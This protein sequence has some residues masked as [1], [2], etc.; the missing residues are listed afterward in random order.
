MV[1]TSAGSVLAALLGAG[2]GVDELLNHHG[3]LPVTTGPLAGHSYD[4]DRATG[5]AMPGRPR[6]G[7]GSSRLLLQSMRSPRSIRRWLP[8]RRCSRTVASRCGLF[9]R[10]SRRSPRTATGRRTRRCGSWPWTTT[11]DG[12]W[13][14]VVPAR[15]LQVWPR[16]STRLARSPVVSRGPIGGRRYVDGGTCSPTSVD[17]LAGADVDEVY[18]LAPMI[19]FDY[20]RPSGFGARAE[21]TFRRTM[22][23]RMLGEAAKVRRAGISVTMLGPGRED[24]EAIGRQ[25]DGSEPPRGRTRGLATHQRRGAAAREGRRDQLHLTCRTVRRPTRFGCTSPQ[26]WP[27]LGRCSAQVSLRPAARAPSQQPCAGCCPTRTLRPWSTRRC[28]TRPSCPST[29]WF[30]KRGWFGVGSCWLPI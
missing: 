26:R 20:D 5:G 25:L 6:P 29:A 16:L 10:W 2:V 1:G 28:S 11:P 30:A 7:I 4:Y 14:S 18:V 13:P 15:R 19:S 12:V 9:L 21:R 22:T 17:L 27:T 8:C 23:R 24:L 3:G